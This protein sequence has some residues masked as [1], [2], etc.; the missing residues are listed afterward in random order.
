M[1]FITRSGL[2]HPTAMHDPAVRHR[3]NVVVGAEVGLLGVGALV[4]GATGLSE[5]IAV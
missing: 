3:Y 5:W 2:Q 1:G 4:L